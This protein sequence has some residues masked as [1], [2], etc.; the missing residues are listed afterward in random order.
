LLLVVDIF[1]TEAQ[2]L[3]MFL[4]QQYKLIH[5]VD[6]Q[7][8]RHKHYL[9]QLFRLVYNKLYKNL[10]KLLDHIALKPNNQSFLN[11]N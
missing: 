8:P 10:Q 6:S 3:E 5:K 7:Y 11:H 4:D 9:H 1:L 2:N